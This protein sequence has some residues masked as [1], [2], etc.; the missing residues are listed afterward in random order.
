M[1][2]LIELDNKSSYGVNAVGKTGVFN[3]DGIVFRFQGVRSSRVES[4]INDG[5]SMEVKTKN[6]TYVFEKM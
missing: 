3:Y 5:I 4:I 1:F 2:K 6:S